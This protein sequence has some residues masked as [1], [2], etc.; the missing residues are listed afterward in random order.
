[1][2]VCVLFVGGFD[3]LFTQGEGYFGILWLLMKTFV[4]GQKSEVC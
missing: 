3:R 4:P 2:R 1:M